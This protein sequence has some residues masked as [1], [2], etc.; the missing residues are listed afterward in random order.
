MYVH[1]MFSLFICPQTL[2]GMNADARGEHHGYLMI[3]ILSHGGSTE[4]GEAYVMT[5]GEERILV[6]EILDK[7]SSES[8]AAFIQKPKIVTILACRLVVNGHSR[9]MVVT[10]FWCLGCAPIPPFKRVV[11]SNPRHQ[12]PWLD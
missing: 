9:C 10:I 8:L 2:D 4:A 1:Y 7:L 5:T 3:W 12:A 6:R 11:S